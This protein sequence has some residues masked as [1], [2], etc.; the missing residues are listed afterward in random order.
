M[1]N[2]SGHIYNDTSCQSPTILNTWSIYPPY[3]SIILPE[4]L[5]L[6]PESSHDDSSNIEILGELI[7]SIWKGRHSQFWWRKKNYIHLR[8]ASGFM[9]GKFIKHHR[10]SN[11][12][13]AE[14]IHCV[15]PIGRYPET[16]FR[17]LKEICRNTNL[18]FILRC[19]LTV[20]SSGLNNES[21]LYFLRN[22]GRMSLFKLNHCTWLTLFLFQDFDNNYWYLHLST[23]PN[24]A[25]NFTFTIKILNSVWVVFCIGTF[26]LEHGP[27]HLYT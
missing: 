4:A 23:F 18:H 27:N 16:M 7:I 9:D 19:G 26:S 8:F 21:G 20:N 22:L 25:L 6:S 24:N 10:T 15:T 2:M 5:N 1:T 11:D 12:V 17:T 13:N 14:S 3:R